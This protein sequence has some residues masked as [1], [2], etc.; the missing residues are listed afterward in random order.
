MGGDVDVGTLLLSP[1]MGNHE[2]RVAYWAV[3][4]V[5][6]ED[7]LCRSRQDRPTLGVRRC[8]R[9]LLDARN[10][11]AVLDQG[12]GVGRHQCLEIDVLVCRT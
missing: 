6:D 4:R 3:F 1:S 12:H 8:H 9:S 5:L 11:G 7:R 10:I 2:H